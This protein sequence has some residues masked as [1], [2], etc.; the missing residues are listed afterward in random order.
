M[1]SLFTTILE[2][3]E[4][5][6]GLS[7]FKQLLFL[8]VLTFISIIGYWLS[9]KIN[10]FNSLLVARINAILLGTANMSVILLYDSATVLAFTCF[11][12]CYLIGLL[13]VE[14]GEYEEQKLIN[15]NSIGDSLY[16]QLMNQIKRN[17]IFNTVISSL[18]ISLGGAIIGYYMS[19]IFI[20]GAF[21]RDF[22]I[23]GSNPSDGFFTIFK[24][25]ILIALPMVTLATVLKNQINLKHRKI[26]FA[27]LITFIFFMGPGTIHLMLIYDQ[28]FLFILINILI[29]IYMIHIFW[30]IKKLIPASKI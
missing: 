13:E 12:I 15:E 11:S 17:K 8:F 20:T 18:I 7:F 27:V 23:F 29:I 22:S 25:G 19:A 5:V 4:D 1:S 24:V 2:P 21:I 14:K 3:S 9:N 26:A 10:N 28:M 30:D 16:L 6:N